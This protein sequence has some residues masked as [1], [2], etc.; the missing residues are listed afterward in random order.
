MSQSKK[1]VSN[2][3]PLKLNIYNIIGTCVEQGIAQGYKH[4]HKHTEKPDGDVLRD[5]IYEDVMNS[6]SE[7]INFNDS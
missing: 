1:R 4:A 3:A 5:H 7:V 2:P 6:L